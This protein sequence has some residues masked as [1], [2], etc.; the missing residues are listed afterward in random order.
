MTPTSVRQNLQR[1]QERIAG[2]A[3]RAGRKAAEITLIAVSKTHPASAIREAYEA[4]IRHFGENRVQEWEGKRAETDGLAATWH[5]IGHLQSNKAARAARLFHSIDSI[6]DFAIAQRLDRAKAEAGITGKLRVLIEVRVA[7]EATK[8]GAEI[9]E[10]LGLAEKTAGLPQLELAGLMCIPP[11]LEQAEQV[12]LYFRRLR[13]LRE[14]VVKKLGMALP[15]L[16]M[17]MSHDF[18]VAIEEGAT[19]VRVGTAIFGTREAK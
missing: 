7:P 2:A 14:D 12:R 3:A 17:G 13:E 8:S 10:L 1:I 6:D 9:N 11:F 19:E 5:L 15:V 18:E 16:S 4:G